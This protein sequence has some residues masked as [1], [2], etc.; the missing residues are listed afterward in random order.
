MVNLTH[1]PVRLHFWLWK[2]YEQITAECFSQG[3]FV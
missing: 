1:A 2:V 3:M